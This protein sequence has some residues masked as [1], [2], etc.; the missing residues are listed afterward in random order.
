MT[1][2]PRDDLPELQYLGKHLLLART[3][4]G[5]TQRQLALRSR[6]DTATINRVERSQRRPTLEQLVR[7]A[8][9][10]QVPLQWFLNASNRPGTDLQ[11]F[12]IELQNLGMADLCIAGARV[13][14]AFRPPEELVALA[15]SAG[16]PEPRIVEA[17]PAV[18]AWN[19]WNARLLLAYGRTSGKRTVHRLAWL[20]DVTLTLDRLFGF[21]AGCP[22]RGDLERF[23]ARV[24]PPGQGDR[25]FPQAP[26]GLG[27][28]TTEARLH[29]VWR[30][31]Q[32]T[33]AADLAAFR[34]RAEHLQTLRREGP[35]A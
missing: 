11:E 28:P 9:V 26:D 31:W 23:L 14:G 27:R 24:Q 21:P 13:P 22:G 4:A 1:T 18:L 20:A 34:S 3:R 12:A 32:I 33:Y 15:V 10:L 16:E 8:Q 25:P 30:R 7:L 29:P 17:L 35:P 19:R 6:I 5:L 2:R